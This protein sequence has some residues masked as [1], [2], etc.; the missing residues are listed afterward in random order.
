MAG[1]FHKIVLCH[2]RLDEIARRRHPLL[3]K[4][5][6]SYASIAGEFTT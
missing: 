6:G 4:K 5:R 2:N 1:L 3:I